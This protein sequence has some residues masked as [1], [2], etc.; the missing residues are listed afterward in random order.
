LLSNRLPS[1]WEHIL[2]QQGKTP[3]MNDYVP[4]GQVAKAHGVKGEIKIYPYSEMPQDF[5][6]F[7]E[8]LFSGDTLEEHQLTVQQARGQGKFAIVKLAG[9]DDKDS[10]EL[11]TGFEVWA[12]K[13]DLPPLQD[14]EF[15]WYEMVGMA[16]VTDTGRALGKVTNLFSTAAH[17][18]LVVTGKGHEY[19]I[20]A[21]N[22]FI[23]R[24]DPESKTLV[25]IPVP[26]LLEIN[27]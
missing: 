20:P 7:R 23:A 14:N 10:A 19:L 25:V 9:V 11:L 8:L 3:D 12:R 4:V 15:Y 16:V 26:G 13:Q 21:K 24:M 18:V 22:E 5:A 2:T 27:D 17:D 1:G 6:G